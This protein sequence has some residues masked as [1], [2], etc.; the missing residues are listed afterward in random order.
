MARPTVLLAS[1]AIAVTSMAGPVSG[2]E[3]AW[4]ELLALVPPR[5]NAVVALDVQAILNSPI[6][7][8]RGWRKQTAFRFAEGAGAIPAEAT[9]LLMGTQIDFHSERPMWDVLVMDLKEFWTPERLVRAARGT[10]VDLGG[11]PAAWSPLNCYYVR[12][13][14]LRVGAI[15]P[16]NRQHALRW[17]K[18]ERRVA[19]TSYLR[20]A[21]DE[22]RQGRAHYLLAVDLGDVFD[23][24]LLRGGF[25]QVGEELNLEFDLDAMTRLFAGL[26]GVSVGARFDVEATAFLR[27]DFAESPEALKDSA[28]P[29]LIEL[30]ARAGAHVERFADW[31]AGARGNAIYLRGQ[32]SDPTLRRLASVLHLQPP[33]DDTEAANLSMGEATRRQFKT[34]E[35]LLNDLR[36]RARDPDQFDDVGVWVEKYAHRIEGMPSS[37]LDA[38][39]LKYRS[40]L[41]GRMQRIADELVYGIDTAAKRRG[42]HK[43]KDAFG[44]TRVRDLSRSE[45]VVEDQ[46]KEIISETLAVR[47]LLSSRY[48]LEF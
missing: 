39:Y 4:D 7:V 6:G 30:L 42:Y 33:V 44:E 41:V 12:L 35:L 37:N 46:A 27:V 40:E 26:R 1:L 8:A 15:G 5:A 34:V 31:E 22:V 48:E 13:S 3:D 16:A 47:K 36:L 11:Y 19:V 9:R 45:T 32:A 24:S 38:D 18:D 17:L 29:L 43:W 21:V 28:R 25:R 23:P 14:P 20:E 10:P 2:G